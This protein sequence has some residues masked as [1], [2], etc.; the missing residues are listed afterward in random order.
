MRQR[1][2]GVTFL[3]WL[4]LLI[5]VAMVG[6]VAIRVT[7]SY[8]GYTKISRAMNQVAE[9]YGSAGAGTTRELIRSSLQK[10]FDV[11]Y[12][13]QIKSKDVTVTKTGEGWVVEASY[14]EVI[15]LIYNASLL[16]QFDKSVTI[17]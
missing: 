17:P 5:P 2:R 15:P 14:E 6:Y 3:G 4:V 13:D 16:L 9:E 10:R 11:D 1:Q 8:L 12:I 7:P